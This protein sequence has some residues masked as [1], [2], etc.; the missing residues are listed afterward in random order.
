MDTGKKIYLCSR[1]WNKKKCL[2]MYL[3][4]HRYLL[5]VYII[6]LFVENKCFH[7]PRIPWSGGFQKQKHHSWSV[8]DSSFFFFCLLCNNIPNWRSKFSFLRS[9]LFIP[10]CITQKMYDTLI[11][12]SSVHL[13]RYMNG[14]CFGVFR[15]FLWFKYCFYFF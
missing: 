10:K 13:K 12:E 14:I 7:S 8:I 15:I 1:K 3:Q 5:V 11:S 9:A 6:R 2:Y 4:N